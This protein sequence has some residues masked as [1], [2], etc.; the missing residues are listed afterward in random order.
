MM[1][2]ILDVKGVTKAVR[3][4]KLVNDM[5]FTVEKGQICG[6][7]GPNGAGKTT[8]IRMITGLI[9]PT[10]GSIAIAGTDVRT[11][12]PE[13]LAKL[14]AIV[15]SPIFFPYLTGSGNLLNLARLDPSLSPARQKERVREVIATV[16]LEGRENDR[17]GTYSLGMK[18]RLGIAQAILG[19]PELI[20]LDEPANGLDPMGIRELRELILKLHE[21]E[22][23]TFLI[24]SHLLDEIQKICPHVVLMKEGKLVWKGKTQELR[25]GNESLEDAFVELMTR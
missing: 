11:R 9:H 21:T 4:R 16:G 5:S 3:S 7:L 10:A 22:G 15:E 17:V 6:L 8:L 13:A 1:N 14:G 25:Q 23:L 2:P 12:R 24:S 19:Q 18:Q 20:I